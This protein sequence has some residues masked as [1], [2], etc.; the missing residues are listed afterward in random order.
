MEIY[1]PNIPITILNCFV[2]AEWHF[3]CILLCFRLQPN[4]LSLLLFFL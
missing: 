4:I 1:V 2:E 3:A